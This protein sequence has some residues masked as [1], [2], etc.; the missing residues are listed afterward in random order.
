MKRIGKLGLFLL[1]SILLLASAWGWLFLTQ[2]EV[3]PTVSHIHRTLP[4]LGVVLLCTAAVRLLFRTGKVRWTQANCG[5]YL[6]FLFTVLC[7]GGLYAFVCQ[8]ILLCAPLE[9]SQLI[10]VLCAWSVEMLIVRFILGTRSAPAPVAVI[11]C[12]KT[13]DPLLR[14]LK[15]APSPKSRVCGIFDES[16][17]GPRRIAGVKRLRTLEDLP[18]RLAKQEV[19]E[20]IVNLPALTADARPTVLREILDAGHRRVKVLP[21]AFDPDKP[22]LPQLRTPEPEDF[23]GH[24]P[25]HPDGE[26]I[27][28]DLAEKVVLVTGGGGLVGAEL[29]RRIAQCHPAKL[30]IVDN[31]EN[32]AYVL[33]QELQRTFGDGLALHVEIASVQ[34][35]ARIHR[36]FLQYRPQIVFHAAA[37]MQVP[38]M[39]TNPEESVRSHVFGTWNLVCAAEEFCTEKFVLLSTAQ[40]VDPTSVLGASKRLCEM[41]L[42]SRGSQNPTLFVTVRFGTVLESNASAVSEFRR[43]IA[44]GGPVTLMDREMTRNFITCREAAQL[45][46][47]AGAMAKQ[48]GV[49]VLYTGRPVKLL[50]LAEDLIRLAGLRPGQDLDITETGLQPGTSM[51]EKPVVAGCHV[52]KIGHPQIFLERQP[53]ISPKEMRDKLTVLTVALAS[54]DPKAARTALHETVLTYHEPRVAPEQ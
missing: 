36:I 54:S 38:L 9:R 34:E 21:A 25:V 14:E 51:Q 3:L 22:L 2:G 52:E 46:L 31:H 11:G 8:D 48:N 17:S 18:A 7:S 23:L 39:E 44:E 1:D 33:Q 47:T 16:D 40:A 53:R 35:K 15:K 50:Q 37:Y 6:S 24:A 42:Q 19:T 43:Q 5:T 26:R 13:A 30:I 41:I 32:S 28:A 29:C 45:V 49:Y 27:R 10:P 20:V 12:G 4:H